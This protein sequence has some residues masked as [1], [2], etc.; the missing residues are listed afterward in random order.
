[1]IYREEYSGD[2]YYSESY[3]ESVVALQPTLLINIPIKSAG[4]YTRIG[5]AHLY[6]KRDY[7]YEEVWS[8]GSDSYSE[9]DDEFKTKAVV[10]VG[11]KYDITTSFTVRTEYTQ[12]SEWDDLI[13]SYASLGA[14]YRF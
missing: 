8:E 4:I 13:I 5:F 3:K 2:G 14:T 9:S 11:F 1:M 12:Y 10:G 7:S 6:S